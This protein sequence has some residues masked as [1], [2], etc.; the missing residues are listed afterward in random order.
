MHYGFLRF[1]G[2]PELADGE[3]LDGGWPLTGKRAEQDDRPAMSR[4]C[5]VSRPPSHAFLRAASTFRTSS[6]VTIL[7]VIAFRTFTVFGRSR[8]TVYA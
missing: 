6:T 1:K 7:L 2:G 8:N 4:C 3:R 5:R